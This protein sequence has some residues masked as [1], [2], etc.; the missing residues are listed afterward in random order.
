MQCALYA[1][2]LDMPDKKSVKEENGSGDELTVG[3]VKHFQSLMLKAVFN[4]ICV[5]GMQLS[6]L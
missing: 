1:N 6:L 3:E 2:G 4:L 5:R